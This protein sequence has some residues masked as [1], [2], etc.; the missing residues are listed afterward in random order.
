MAT[1]LNKSRLRLTQANYYGFYFNSGSVNISQGVGVTLTPNP[2]LGTGSI[3]VSI[4][5]GD[6]SGAVALQGASPGTAQTGNINLTGSRSSEK[7][8]TETVRRGRRRTRSLRIAHS[9]SI[10]RLPVRFPL[11][12]AER[13]SSSSPTG[14]SVSSEHRQPRRLLRPIPD[15][16]RCREPQPRRCRCGLSGSSV[17]HGT[18]RDG[19]QHS[20]VPETI[21]GSLGTGTG[22]AGHVLVKVGTPQTTGTAQHVPNTILDLSDAG[23]AGTSLPWTAATGRLSLNATAPTLKAQFQN[24]T[25]DTFDF[26]GV[27][28][29]STAFGFA[30]GS[31]GTPQTTALTSEFHQRWDASNQ[32][33]QNMGSFL[34]FTK[35]VGGNGGCQGIMSLCEGTGGDTAR[36]AGHIAITAYNSINPGTPPTL[37]WTNYALWAVSTRNQTHQRAVGA[38]FDAI[39]YSGVD[40]YWDAH[41]ANDPA[42]SIDSTIGLAINSAG[43]NKGSVAITFQAPADSQW[44]TGIWFPTNSI[45]H[46]AI[47]AGA[48]ASTITPIRIAS[49]SK[50]QARNAGDTADLTLIRALE[51][52]TVAVGHN[53]LQNIGAGTGNTAIGYNTLATNVTGVNSTAVGLGAL[54]A[55]T[56]S[57]NTAFGGSC[58]S[59][60]TGTNNVAIGN[61]AGHYETGSNA[62]YV[63]NQDRTNTAGD[64]AG[65]ILYG[66]M[67]ASA[68][69]QTLQVNA[70]LGVGA[71]PNTQLDVNGAMSTRQLGITVANGLNSNI[72]LTNASWV[73]LTGPTGGFS[74]GGF[75]GPFDGRRLTIY[76][77]VAQQMTIV[78]EDGSSTAGNRI[79]T[80]TGANVVLRAGTSAATM[81]YD[82]TDSRWILVSYN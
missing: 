59:L 34:F 32:E 37:G 64:K 46:Y 57:N 52:G 38:E 23:S 82:A 16:A 77:T 30:D 72:I 80:L 49:G 62:F 28:T 18:E 63:D 13:R 6:S 56:G 3:A 60:T 36:M 39:N 50:I 44:Q 7:F 79:K 53:A 12:S 24:L 54:Q 29:G 27:H 74:I 43:G 76:N 58:L 31:S 2:I 48:L 66:V 70:K 21:T 22:T 19:H 81:I 40:A 68:A 17:P 55:S 35:K 45:G 11:L 1:V 9:G 33:G 14:N 25:T 26:S 69:N 51:Q 71:S 47:D 78:N 75:T 41:V 8:S 15:S 4:T 65:A 5:P 20:A 73:R 10:S 42:G 61:F 67:A